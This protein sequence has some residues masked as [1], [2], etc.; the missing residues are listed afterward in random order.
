MGQKANP[1]GN[2]LGIIRGWE[3]NWFGGKDIATKV[4]EDE[5]IRNYIRHRIV[6]ATSTHNRPQP[7][8]ISRIIIE[9]SMKR[10]TVNIYA[11]RIGTVIGRGGETVNILREELKKLTKSEVNINIFEVR[12]PDLDAAIVAENIAKQI[13]SRM[14]YRRAIKMAIQNTMRAQGAE[15]IKVRVGGRLNGAEIARREEYKEGRTP[16]HT[17]RA[18]IDYALAEAQTVYGKIGVRVWICRGEVFG[19]RELSAFNEVGGNTSFGGG[20][21]RRDDRRGGDRDRDSSDR[22]PGDRS[23]PGDRTK[24][25]GPNNNRRGGGGGPNKGGGT[26]G[27]R[28]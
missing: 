28:R 2:R 24:P 16:L 8:S 12:K 1:I 14:N 7:S 5:K 10:I 19:K 25:G 23:K 20:Q 15:G 4:V 22:K 27:G 17:F 6:R 11:G 21:Q 3:S 18:D 9:R 26:G 13:E